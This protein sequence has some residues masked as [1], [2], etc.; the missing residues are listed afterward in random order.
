MRVIISAG[1]TGGHINP[2]LAIGRYI[3][4]Q[5]SENEVLFIGALGDMDKKLY[6]ECG[7]NYRLFYSKGLD[8]KNLINN[9][10]IL[11]TDYKAYR[12]I[13]KVAEEFKPDVGISCGGY[14]SAMAMMCLKKKKIPFIIHEQNAI[15]GLTTKLLSRYAVKYAY[16]FKSANK[17]LKFPE[18]GVYSGNPIREDFLKHTKEEAREKLGFSNDDKIILCFGGSLGARK[19]NEVFKNMIPKI[20]NDNV[21]LVIGTGS[22]YYKEY[23][24]IENGNIIIKEYI[25][26]MPLWLTAC[27]IAVTR[28]GA[29]TVSELCAIKK[30]SVLIPSP[31]V[32]ADHQTKN[33]LELSNC[34]GAILIR[35]NELSDE[36]LYETLMKTVKDEEKL[37]KMENAL[38]PLSVTDGAKRIYTIISKITH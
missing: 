37:K 6:G 17:Y 24:K 15:P 18:R 35:E 32:T 21:K 38:T 3:L 25:D 11:K 31:N 36:L 4:E 13:L 7:M 19:L 8:R 33:A 20:K 16:A 9:F 10:N 14:I 28:A 12:D 34:G 26:N 23:E 2:A 27:D 22:Y 5:N 29:M 30:P 1:G